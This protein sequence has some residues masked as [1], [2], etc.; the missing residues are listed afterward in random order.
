MSLATNRTS[1]TSQGGAFAPEHDPAVGPLVLSPSE[2]RQLWQCYEELLELHRAEVVDDEQFENAHQ[3][4]I[5]QV[6][7]LRQI[8]RDREHLVIDPRAGITE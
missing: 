5:E 7:P 3:L 6:Q 8:L 4:L 1:T 2:L